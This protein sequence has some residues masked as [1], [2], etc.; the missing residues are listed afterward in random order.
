MFAIITI[1][2]T[3]VVWAIVLHAS[4]V[5]KIFHYLIQG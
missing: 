2:V 5:H 4:L 3:G 1:T